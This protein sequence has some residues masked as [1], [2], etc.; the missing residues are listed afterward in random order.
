MIRP[1]VLIMMLVLTASIVAITVSH[2]QN[3]MASAYSG[4][5]GG[6][7]RSGTADLD[8]AES[9]EVENSTM[10][11]ATNQTTTNSTS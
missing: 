2:S 3:G 5:T 10:A 1:K 4:Q 8:V 9:V 11:K 6:S 7:T